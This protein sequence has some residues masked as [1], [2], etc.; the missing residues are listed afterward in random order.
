MSE[1]RYWIKDTYVNVC[2]WKRV[3]MCARA[4]IYVCVRL[5]YL[6]INKCKSFEKNFYQ[7]SYQ[8]I[9]ENVCSKNQISGKIKKLQWKWTFFINRFY[10]LKEN[11]LFS[12]CLLAGIQSADKWWSWK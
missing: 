9:I 1:K 5:V 12:K 11:G 10:F 4:H 7:T 6:F 2:V 8:N 3:H